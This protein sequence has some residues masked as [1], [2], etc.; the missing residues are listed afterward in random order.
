MLAM[1][2]TSLQQIEEIAQGL[3]AM[4]LVTKLRQQGLL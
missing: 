2:P 4:Q 1:L 3:R